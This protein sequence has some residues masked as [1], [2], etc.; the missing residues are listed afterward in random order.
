MTSLQSSLLGG[1]AN[2]SW[3]YESN[4]PCYLLI[5]QAAASSL[6]CLP[7]GGASEGFFDEW[8]QCASIANASNVPV[9]YTRCHMTVCGSGSATCGGG[10]HSLCSSDAELHEVRC[11]SDTAI[12]GWTHNTNCTVYSESDAWTEGCQILNFPTAEAFCLQQNARLC[13][14]TEVSA[15]CARGSGC[16]HDGDPIWTSTSQ[17]GTSNDDDDSDDGAF[18]PTVF[19]PTC[20]GEGGTC[21]CDGAVIYGATTAS[22]SV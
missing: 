17:P 15:S 8:V 14:A 20:A 3:Q 2:A 1:N 19:G 21:Q 4:C 9:N 18:D 12:A 5:P 22:Q 11:C 16:G 13:T 7:Y 10:Q 6:T